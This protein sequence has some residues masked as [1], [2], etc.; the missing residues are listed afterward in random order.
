MQYGIRQFRDAPASDSRIWWAAGIVWLL[1]IVV[2]I[3]ATRDRV[4]IRFLGLKLQYISPKISNA[5]PKHESS[6]VLVTNLRAVSLILTTNLHACRAQAF[7]ELFGVV[8][9]LFR[10]ASVDGSQLTLGGS[11]T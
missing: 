9:S 3:A 11:P 1:I 8:C 7:E 2:I 5:K 10:Q 6:A 4:F